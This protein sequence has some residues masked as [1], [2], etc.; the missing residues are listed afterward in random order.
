MPKPIRT[1][2]KRQ[3]LSGKI[4]GPGSQSLRIEQQEYFPDGFGFLLDFWFDDE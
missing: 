1:V 2:F 4:A 3:R